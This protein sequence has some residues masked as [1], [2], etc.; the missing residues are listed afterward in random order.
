[1]L[2]AVSKVFGCG[3]MPAGQASTRCFTVTGFTLA[4][5]MVY[6]SETSVLTRV[7]GIASSKNGAQAFARLFVM[8]TVCIVLAG[9]F[10]NE[11]NLHAASDAESSSIIRN[12]AEEL[13]VSQRTLAKKFHQ[14]DFVHK[15]PRQDL[16]E[17]TRLWVFDVLELQA[18]RALLSDALIS[19]ILG[20]LTVTSATNHCYVWQLLSV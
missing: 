1:M 5:A 16:H 2:A 20:Q 8:Q 15:K 3:I 7:P 18:R 12:L 13:D 17:L 19:V 6:S 11:S 4:L 10:L 9:D 14:F